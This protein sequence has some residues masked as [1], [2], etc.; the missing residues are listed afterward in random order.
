MTLD[1]DSA[2]FSKAIRSAILWPV[3]VIFV[4][5]LFLLIFVFELFQDVKWSDHSYKVLA[6]MR[7][8]ENLVIS[9]QNNVRG[10]LLTGDQSFVTS[11]NTDCAQIDDQFVKLKKL[12]GDN[13]EQS[14]RADDLIQA[15]NTWI[16]QSK[17]MISHRSE[18]L[19]INR[20]WILMGKSIM[21]QVRAKF[22]KFADV[23]EGLRDA[24]VHKV[25]VMKTTLAYAGSLLALLVAGVVAQQVRK[26][27]MALAGSYRE[28]LTTIEQRHAELVRSEADLEEQKERL[29]VTLTSIGD[30]VI[31]TDKDG[32]VVLMNHESERMTGWNNKEALH[33]PITTVFHIISEITRQPAEDLVARILKEKKVIGLANHTLLISRNADEWPIEDSAAPI[34]DAK[35]KI[36]GV[37][38]VFHD[39]TE[40]R[41]AQKALKAH[42]AD[43]EKQVADRT[44]TLQQ[45]IS[46]LE[47]FSYTVSHDLR[48]P[49]RAM[50]GF[51]DAIAEDY[52]DKLD[53]QGKDYLERI[54]KAASRMDLL[55]QDLLSYT[56]ISRQD[57]PMEPLDLDKIVRDAIEREPNLNPPNG[58]V[59]I[60]GILPR[61][62]G[63]ESALTQVVSNLLGN[64]AKFVAEGKSPE[65]RIWSEDRGPRVC[66]W[67]E[68]NGIGISPQDHERVFQMFVQINDNKLYKGTGVGLAIVKKA[69]QTMR[70][71]VG[72]ESDGK[73]GTRFW[74]E[75]AK[76]T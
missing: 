25:A 22:D 31:V 33:Q 29:H 46:E 53:D 74:V 38:I 71:S 65:L 63:R 15:K 30:G 16:E 62:L 69:V 28:A 59:R 61:V 34:F 66:L 8:C 42:S 52:S 6:E 72:V 35:G 57:V 55:I 27:M 3:G 73:S 20:D 21:D 58:K 17:T 13:P 49:L 67:I 4:S 12:V 68:D 26:Q 32:L 9:T 19:P 39:A 2:R 51:S 23:E 45:A 18:N 75:L 50:Q 76:A 64:A 54:K 1:S 5:A 24:R 41:L 56:R 60:E 48:A 47:T 44:T 37:V 7:V 14:I 40:I 11:Y 70:G 36:L 10:Y 43:L